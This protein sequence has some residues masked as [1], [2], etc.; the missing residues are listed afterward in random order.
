MADFIDKL[1][2]VK[3]TVAG[4]LTK[5]L[6]SRDDDNILILAVWRKQAGRKVFFYSSIQKMLIKGKLSTPETITRSRRLLQQHHIDLRGIMYESRRI[7]EDLMRN[8]M[9]LDL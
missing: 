3:S 9:K 8:Q 1:I 4:I 5:D 7:Q 6:L 2:T